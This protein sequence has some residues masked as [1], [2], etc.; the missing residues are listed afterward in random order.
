MVE[1]ENY[2]RCAEDR[3]VRE[4]RQMADRALLTMKQW[5]NYPAERLERHLKSLPKRLRAVVKAHGGY[6]KY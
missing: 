3:E 2:R 4:G 6:T 5:A 1:F